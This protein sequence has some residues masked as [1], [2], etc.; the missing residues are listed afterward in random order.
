MKKLIKALSTCLLLVVMAI[1]FVACVPSN[2]EKAK[3]KMQEAGYKVAAYTDD[4]EDDDIVGGFIAYK[5]NK[6]VP[7]L[8]AIQF[9]SNDEAKD[10]F[11][12][13]KD[14]GLKKN[15]ERSGKRVFWGNSS[16]IEE[17]K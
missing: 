12:D 16:A 4:D 5:D 7:D 17:F 14:N 8:T 13:H 1:T 9:D 11:E 2:V 6:L 15:I 10:Y 3:E